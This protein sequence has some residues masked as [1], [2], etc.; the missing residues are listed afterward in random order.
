MDTRVGFEPRLQGAGLMNSPLIT[1]SGEHQGLLRSSRTLWNLSLPWAGDAV[2]KL[3]VWGEAGGEGEAGEGVR[4]EQKAPS[5][6]DLRCCSPAFE[7]SGTSF[8]TTLWHVPTCC[9]PGLLLTASIHLQ[10]TARQP[11]V[12]QPDKH[13]PLSKSSSRTDHQKAMGPLGDGPCPLATVPSTSYLLATF[14]PSH[15]FCGC[16]WPFQAVAVAPRRV[17]APPIP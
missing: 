4:R 13:T 11:G 10:A 16:P 1:G 14:H 5:E 2:W 12:P 9:W 17:A 15:S 8:P 3:L 7:A 6:G